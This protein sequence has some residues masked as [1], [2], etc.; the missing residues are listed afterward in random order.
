LS[1]STK[2]SNLFQIGKV[3]SLLK[4]YS[5]IENV[6]YWERD[7]GQNIIEY[8]E[9]KLGLCDV[10]VLFCTQNSL[11]S[12]SVK[13]EWTSAFHMTQ[14]G[15][16]K[17]IPVCKN[18]KDIPLLLR[19]M[20]RID[21]HRDNFP[22]FIEN[23]FREITRGY[24]SEKVEFKEVPI[25]T[26]SVKEDL[27]VETD[28]FDITTKKLI[29]T[30]LII[31]FSYSVRDVDEFKL[32]EI[33]N[34]LEKFD[35]IKKAHLFHSHSYSYG[36]KVKNWKNILKESSLLIVFVSQNSDKSKSVKKEIEAAFDMKIPVVPVFKDRTFLPVFLEN[37]P[38]IKFDVLNLKTTINGLYS[39]I[40]EVINLRQI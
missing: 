39:R 5:E 35:G 29:E 25:K 23:L 7:S 12:K 40:I 21:F 22:L 17:I 1:Y 8:M 15:E 10:F 28:R 24:E 36:P 13:A 4:K 37:L 6:F 2:D 34:E 30:P 14:G 11:K 19:P 3:A 33:A 18:E 31:Y 32:P 20:L 27:K 26:V 16:I 38:G 9:E